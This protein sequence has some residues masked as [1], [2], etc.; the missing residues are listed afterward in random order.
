MRHYLYVP[1]S[2][3][4]DKARK[5]WDLTGARPIITFTVPAGLGGNLS[6]TLNALDPVPAAGGRGASLRSRLVDLLDG[7][8][9]VE[10]CV[11]LSL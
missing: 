5:T 10:D 8:S 2:E 9:V 11:V 1:F 4:R 7:N 6:V 3:F